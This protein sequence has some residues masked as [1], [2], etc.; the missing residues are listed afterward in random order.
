M[1]LAKKLFCLGILFGF[2]QLMF[3]Q[4]QSFPAS[5]KIAT[6]YSERDTIFAFEAGTSPSSIEFTATAPGGVNANFAWS[7]FD[8][9]TRV[10]LAPVF[11]ENNQ[12]SSTYTLPGTGGYKLH[13]TNGAGLDSTFI[14]W[15]FIDSL[16][17]EIEK[18]TDGTVYRFNYTCDY[19]DLLLTTKLNKFRYFNPSTGQ[20]YTFPNKI[21]KYEWSANPAPEYLPNPKKNGNLRISTHPYED[22]YYSVTI[23]DTLGVSMTDQALFK[24]IKPKADFELVFEQN[25]QGKNSA[26]LDVTFTNNCK[27]VNKYTWYTGLTYPDPDTV[28]IENPGPLVYKEPGTYTIQLIT[29]SIWHCIDSTSRTLEVAPPEI[30]TM[31]AFTPNGDGINET[32]KVTNISIKQCKMTIFSRWGKL[33]YEKEIREGEDFSAWEG[34][35][36]KIKETNQDASPGIYFFVLE[37]YTFEKKPSI[38]LVYKDFFYLFRGDN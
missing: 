24:A 29:E 35:N 4:F 19:I 27:N 6:P 30:T 37:I 21:M 16:R 17:T 32:F 12:L 2:C 10:F 18:N 13:I 25:D 15:T 33:V 34:W 5:A 38:A 36:G 23:T 3:G 9:L 1:E 7:R 22:T 31:K 11:N 20:G 26:P 28:Y 14:F 8:T